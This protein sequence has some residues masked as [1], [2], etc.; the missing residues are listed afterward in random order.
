MWDNQGELKVV[1]IGI[2]KGAGNR[3]YH[4]EDIQVYLI[5]KLGKL[6]QCRS[7]IIKI[8]RYKMR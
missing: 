3:R 4:R 6:K 7:S 5:K 1:R 2:R 8:R